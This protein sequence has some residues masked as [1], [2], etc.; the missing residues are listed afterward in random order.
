MVKRSTSHP[1][2]RS[3]PLYTASTLRFWFSLFRLLFIVAHGQRLEHD[4]PEIMD[5]FN[6]WE[7]ADAEI[8][9]TDELNQYLECMMVE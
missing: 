2:Y 6:E 3:L 9:S 1:V 7:I 4:I 5:K 8:M